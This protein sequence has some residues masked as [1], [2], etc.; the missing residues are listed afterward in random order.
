MMILRPALS[1]LVLPFFL[2]ASHVSAQA[3]FFEGFDGQTV[4][5][6][7]AK[8]WIFRNQSQPE[9]ALGW[10]P[11]DVTSAYA[12]T[13]YLVTDGYCVSGGGVGSNWALLPAVAGQQV[14]D[15]LEMYLAEGWTGL[16]SQVLEVRYSPS[17]G[18]STGS[19]STDLGDFTVLLDSF[20]HDTIGWW[21]A[22]TIALPGS[23]RIALR[24]WVPNGYAAGTYVDSLTVGATPTGPIPLPE[25]GQTVQWTSALSPIQF[26]AGSANI[27]AGGQVVV[28]PGV[29]VEMDAGATLRVEG[30]LTF[31]PGSEL[32]AAPGAEVEAWYGGEVSF[33]GD[34]A[35]PV[36]VT[37]DSDYFAPL[38]WIASGSTLRM[39]YAE[40]DA[41]TW[42]AAGST[43]TVDHSTFTTASP[44]VFRASGFRTYNGTLAVRNSSF[45]DG[46]IVE[47]GG[48]LLFDAD[49]FTNTRLTLYRLASPQ[50]L[51][52]DNLVATDVLD[53]APFE[54][55]RFDAF[56]GPDN[57]IQNNLFPVRLETGGVA[58]GSV[59]PRTGNGEN[60]VRGL[61]RF[62][63]RATW[64]D[65]G[66]PYVLDWDDQIPH[67]SGRLTIEPGV[68]ARFRRGENTTGDSFWV[69][70]YADLISR[71]T[72]EAPITL[73]HDGAGWG[74]LFFGDADSKRPKI[75]NTLIEYADIGVIAKLCTVRLVDCLLRNNVVGAQSNSTGTLV[76]RGTRFVA[77]G[78]G[79]ETSPGAGGSVLSAGRADLSGLTNPN[80][81]SGNGLGADIQN[82]NVAVDARGNWWGA[83]SGP[84]HPDNPGGAGDTATINAAVTPFLTSAPALD[85]APLVQVQRVSDVLDAGTRLILRW[86]AEDDGTIVEQRIDFSPHGSN[87]PLAPLVSGLAGDVRTFEIVVPDYVPSSNLQLPVLRVVA[88]DDT[89]REGWDEVRFFT[90]GE[91]VGPPFTIDALPAVV[92]P[93]EDYELCWSSPGNGT[94]DVYLILDDVDWAISQGGT[95]TT[96]LSGDV[97]IPSVSTDLARITVIRNGRYEY[98]DYFSIRPDPAIGDQA[99]QVQFVGPSATLFPEGSVVRLAWAASDDEAL[100]SFDVQ[101]SY[102]GGRGWNQLVG[103]LPGDTTEWNWQLP[104]STQDG[105]ILVRV[106]ATDLRF[107]TSSATIEIET[108]PRQARPFR[109]AEPATPKGVGQAH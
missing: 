29:V 68:T 83:A 51:H 30:R 42:V 1:L 16:A 27:E 62:G 15:E 81:F 26:T 82:L 91:N 86:D 74:G 52:L 94:S 48:Y 60:V 11:A 88:V 34:A 64:S 100:R 102:D 63:S 72:P 9:G 38:L 58:P 55:H 61:A 90:P 80:T 79:A 40:V 3:S 19:S 87:P 47:E 99:P 104:A 49:V 66:L 106:V 45:T 75:T 18:T 77:N 36:T 89:G 8:G 23:G 46:W 96:C 71:G 6:L 107:Q 53:G 70:G 20:E 93:G 25:P 95:T 39:E 78:T 43:A 35:D 14:G 4:G 2:G 7:E 65:A 37:G 69:Q 92:R 5:D 31:L 22:H 101:A 59:L 84:S 98:T 109:S 28:E 76:A 10:R 17:G 44:G 97:T 50:T 32:N 21:E 105:P 33:L 12:G 13:H 41:F 85:K 67:L 54:V 57:V 108:G 56:F 103:G 24:S 73:T